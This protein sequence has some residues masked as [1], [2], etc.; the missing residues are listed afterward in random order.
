MDKTKFFDAIRKDVFGGKLTQA[1][2][3][4]VELLLDLLVRMGLNTHFTAYILATV[5]WETGRTFQPVREGFDASDEWRKKNLR[6]Y[7]WY[8]RGYVQLT[9]QANYEKATTWFKR[10]LG[11]A[12]DFV[13]N[14]DLALD[15]RYSAIITIA[16]MME[17]WFTGKKLSDYL[18]G[19]TFDA[20]NA[21]RIVN[22]KDRAGEIAGISGDFHQALTQA[23]YRGQGTSLDTAP[24]VSLLNPSNPAPESPKGSIGLLPKIVAGAIGLG[25]VA[26][27]IIGLIK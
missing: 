13:A 21:R 17:G 14:K 12:V 5:A 4:G 7:P 24:L 18:L 8:G 25:A 22:G 19:N 3:A 11:V 20:T 27:T 2:V 6:Y 15:P 26:L 16:G 10:V 9:W 1:Q 23:G